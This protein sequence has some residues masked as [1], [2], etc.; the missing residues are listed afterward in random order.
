MAKAEPVK[1]PT[2]EETLKMQQRITF[3]WQRTAGLMTFCLSLA[4]LPFERNDARV[5]EDLILALI[6]LFAGT[7]FLIGANK[8]RKA[9]GFKWL[10]S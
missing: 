2:T 5:T 7:L 4:L 1:K 10:Q 6:G 9:L 8:T 3:W